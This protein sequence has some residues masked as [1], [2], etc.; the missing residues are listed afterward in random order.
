MD[1]SLPEVSDKRTLR[2]IW[3]V[4]LDEIYDSS[5]DTAE[6]GRA[7]RDGAHCELGMLIIKL[8][9]KVPK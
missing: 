7:I 5:L 8:Y 4:V 3:E 2:S 6:L 9:D 1:M